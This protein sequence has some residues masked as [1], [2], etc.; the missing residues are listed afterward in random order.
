MSSFKYR[1]G[2]KRTASPFPSL[3]NKIIY[4]TDAN[5]PPHV[6][7]DALKSGNRHLCTSGSRLFYITRT[8]LEKIVPC[9][10]VII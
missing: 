6:L 7:R 3:K 1:F 8:Q 4:P 5:H 10:L 9:L 2:S